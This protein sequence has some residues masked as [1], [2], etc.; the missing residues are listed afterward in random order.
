MNLMPKPLIAKSSITIHAPISKVWEALTSRG[1]IKQYFYGVDT[2]TDWKAGSPIIYRGVWEGKPFE[3]KGNVLKSEPPKLLVLN[4][5]SPLSGLADVPENYQN[6]TYALVE[7][8]G[9]T[10]LTI[11]NDH[12]PDE[13][14][15]TH[16]EQ[17]W[18]GVLDSLKALLEK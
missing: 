17:N 1:L 15:K 8:A 13:E 12:N 7:R 14:S 2:V 3:D 18:K 11:S 4:H 16:S 5:W 10:E 9:G 6:V